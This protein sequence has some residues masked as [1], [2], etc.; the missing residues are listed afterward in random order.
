MRAGSR[1]IVLIRLVL[2][3]MREKR[4]GRIISIS[5]VGGMMAMPT[6]A[7][8]SA[9]KFALEGACEALWYEVRP[10]DISHSAGARLYPF[11]WIHAY[12]LH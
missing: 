11:R 8:Y 1:Q 9:S 2:P 5:S 12:P 7:L 4:A 6:M 3:K 10:W